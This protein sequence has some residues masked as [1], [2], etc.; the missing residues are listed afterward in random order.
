M[1]EETCA[2]PYT[3]EKCPKVLER[4]VPVSVTESGRG[5]GNYSWHTVLSDSRRY[6]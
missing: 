5:F 1:E 3:S 4:F 2:K 6:H